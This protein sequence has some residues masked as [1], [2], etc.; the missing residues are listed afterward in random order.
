[1]PITILNHYGSYLTY[2]QTNNLAPPGVQ[3]ALQAS[4]NSM[5]D[6]VTALERILHTPVP[7][8]Y[9]I[10]LYQVVWVYLLLLPFQWVKQ[11]EWVAIPVCMFASFALFGVINIGR[12]LENPFDGDDNDL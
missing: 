5:M 7:L 2:V 3:N 12:E 10:F 6:S 4:L 9:V 1:V 8:G 11:L